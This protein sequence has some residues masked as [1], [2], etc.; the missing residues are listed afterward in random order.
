MNV[1]K[2]FGG[3]REGDRP[4]SSNR[5]KKIRYIYQDLERRLGKGAADQIMAASDEKYLGLQKQYGELPPA[6]KQHTD[7]IFMNAAMYLCICDHLPR[8]DAYQVMEDATLKYA[9]PIGNLLDKATR[10]PG[11]PRLFIKVFQKMLLT[12]FNEEA[13]F[14][15]TYHAMTGAEISVDITACP[16][17]RYFTEAGCPELCKCA[18]ISDDA[19]YGHMR[20][21]GFKRTQTLGRGGACCDFRFRVQ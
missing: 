9:I 11:M 10:L 5:H 4:I 2:L 6:V 7:M 21:I 15:S 12:S 19:C 1:L 18:C 8:E 14:A 20:H 17:Q 3:N 13:G 16:Y